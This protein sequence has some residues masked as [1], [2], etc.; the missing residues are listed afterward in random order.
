MTDSALGRA[1]ATEEGAVARI[2]DPVHDILRPFAD[3]LRF[4]FEPR[5]VAVIGA[6]EK[7]GSV[8]RVTFSNLITSSF[9]GQVFPVN[10]HRPR[11]LDRKAFPKI[12]MVPDKID[13]AVIATPAPTVPGVIRECVE[14]GVKT[15]VILSAGFREIGAEGLRLENE[16]KSLSAGKMRI[17]GPNCLGLMNPA[18]GLNA[19]FAQNLA[20]PGQVAF[21]SQS[22]ALCTAI[23]DWS[24]EEKVG[25]SAFVSVG[26]MVDVE[27]G[28]LIDYFSNDPATSSIVIYMESIPNARSFLSA[29][30]AAALTKPI[31]VIKAGRTQ[32]AAKAAAS[33]TGALTGNDAVLDAAFRRVGVLRVNRISDVFHMADLLAKQ[34]LP[35]GP[36]LGILTN[37]GGPGVLAADS[38]ALEGNGTLASLSLETI[39][40]LSTFLPEHWSHGNPIDIIGDADAER[41]GK[42]MEV[43]AKD[44]A[45]DGILVIL[46]PQGMTDP[47]AV[48]SRIAPFANLPGKPVLVSF[49]GGSSVSQGTNLLANGG[50]PTF[51]FP[52]D[53]VRA[54]GEMW[55]Y[56]RNIENLYET[57]ALREAEV[58]PA[59]RLWVT[60]LLA[61]IRSSGRGILSE[62]ESKQVLARYGIPVVATELAASA[63]EAAATA[64]KL[65]FPVVL[66]V[67]SFKV[68]HKSDIG[69]VRLGISTVR[70]VKAAYE[71]I[72]AAVE[73]HA[74]AD[75]FLGVTVQPMVKLE[76]FELILGSSV[77]AQFGP[78]ILFGSGGQLVEVFQDHALSLPPL[79]ATLARRLLERTKIFKAFSGVRGRTPVNLPK[80]ES[81][82]VRF[83]DLILD[84][85]LI[86][87][88]DINPLLASGEEFLAMDARILV[89]PRGVD[90]AS[91]PRPAIRPYPTQ[92][93]V[94]WKMKDGIQAQI[95]AV[96]P[97][98]E[99]SIVAF[100]GRLSGATVE[101]RY[102]HAFD[103]SERTRHARLIRI[104]HIDYD[105]E[106]ALVCERGQELIGVARL[107]RLPDETA[108]ELS[109]VVEDRFQGQGLGT[110]MVRRLL[111]V[112]SV[113]RIQRV[114][115]SLRDDNFRMKHI[116]SSFGFSSKPGQS[117][118]VMEKSL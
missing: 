20:Q 108:A 69:G 10:P 30:R 21:L 76:G 68:T 40:S 45:L 50:I 102:G 23:L 74:G 78:V 2:L 115:A 96:R 37:A 11:V 93:S 29:A 55:N 43:V 1:S 106:I 16:I 38:L 46:T 116:F 5:T 91:I 31:I 27:W 36:N 6:T 84:Q 3:P 33:H 64:E 82:L 35:K 105:R 83:S 117:L 13:L 15:A 92:Y 7:E 71:E 66:K 59:N 17:M 87:E 48:A 94:P 32:A 53:A 14:A 28:A 89:Q 100:H 114:C 118:S 113:E 8:G 19:T 75:A 12:G 73:K 42:A 18:L 60:D 26:S 9:K 54:Y 65:G 51:A 62:H 90:I 86:A 88:T 34:P 80:L 98:D 79:N 52:D 67:H 101:F 63:E 57:P 109:L 112:A 77:D 58:D 72:R 111:K 44:P 49:M 24:L 70:E 39:S 97:E 47:T 41:Y 56:H 103:F 99:K 81:L 25:F 104:C 85:P 107:F 22:G 95:R 4:F 61:S 110:E